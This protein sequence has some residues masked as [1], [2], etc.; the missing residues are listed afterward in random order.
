M[1][2]LSDFIPVKP[3]VADMKGIHKLRLGFL[4][5]QNQNHYVCWQ[6]LIKSYRSTSRDTY[7]KWWIILNI[8]QIQTALALFFLLQELA[9]D[10]FHVT[11]WNSKIQIKYM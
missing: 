8:F 7:I 5:Y 10:H 1:L 9:M 11:S 2:I 4:Q 6:L 3:W